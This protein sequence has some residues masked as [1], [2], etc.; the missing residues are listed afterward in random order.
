MRR[1]LPVLAA[2]AIVAALGLG[3]L[4]AP[5]TPA[6]AQSVSIVDFAFQQQTLTI[7]P[8]DTVTWTN[9][10]AQ[11]HTATSDAGVWDS[12]TITPT[13]TFAFTFTQ[14]GSFPYHCTI[15][16]GMTGTIVV[17]EPTNTPTQTRTPAATATRTATPSLTPATREAYLPLIRRAPNAPT[18]TPRSSATATGTPHDR[19]TPRPTRTPTP[20]PTLPPPTYNN[21]QADPNPSAA[22]NY[23]VRI[24][25]ID[26]AAE[27]VTLRNVT[28]V[29]SI[30]LT[31]WQMCSI[32]GNQHHPISGTLAPGETKTF[33]NNGGPIWNNSASDPGALY[34]ENGQLVS[35]FPD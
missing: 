33:P 23:P 4:A 27:T 6:A 35:Y 13:T 29:D 18:A 2:T 30:D 31:S 11:D 16:P 9:N 25:D 10:G 12:D 28:V 3:A 14:T 19:P 7:A 34:N 1:L 8:G 32:T 15:H 17:A 5:P 20:T 26:K 24:V 21:C 22:P